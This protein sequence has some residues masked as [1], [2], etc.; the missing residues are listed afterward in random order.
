MQSTGLQ[1]L[2]DQA[3]AV[4]ASGPARERQ[5]YRLIDVH[6]S[7]EA[8]SALQAAAAQNSGVV[9][10]AMIA[11]GDVLGAAYEDDARDRLRYALTSPE[12]QT[13]LPKW[14]HE[15]R[16]VASMRPETGACTVG[17]ALELWSWTMKYFRAGEGSRGSRAPVAIDELCAAL[18]PLLAARAFVLEVA[19]ITGP[20]AP[21]EVEWRIDLSHVHAARASAAAGAAC[22]ELVFGYRKHKTWDADGCAGCY[23]GDEA[24]G[25]DAMIPGFATGVRITNDVVESDGTH[26]VK[27]GPC[28]SFSGLD[29]FTKLRNRLDG[30]LT[31][32]RNAK[33]RAAAALGRSMAATTSEGKP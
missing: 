24:D 30:C 10:A 16:V 1:T 33:D 26:A 12:F 5:I 25:L 7:A 22:A 27:A 8:T 32:A 13:L 23:A 18:A 6:A 2:A 29:S 20:A 11:A 21:A 28:A 31:G 17:S 14:I 9:A 15:L 3:R 4:A 19:E